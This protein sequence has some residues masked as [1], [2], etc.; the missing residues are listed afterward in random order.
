MRVSAEVLDKIRIEEQKHPH[1]EFGGFLVVKSN[2]YVKDIVF[3]MASQSAGNV[4]LGGKEVIKLN[5]RHRKMVKGWF[6]K[7]PITGLSPTDKNTIIKLTKFWGICYTMVLQSNGKIL[8]LKTVKGKEFGNTPVYLNYNN[9]DFAEIDWSELKIDWNIF[10]FWK[11]SPAQSKDED[12]HETKEKDNLNTKNEKKSQKEDIEVEKTPA[13]ETKEDLIQL[14]PIDK[15][16]I[17]EVFRKEIPFG[18][19]EPKKSFTDR[20][21]KFKLYDK[22]S[23]TMGNPFTLEMI[24][25]ENFIPFTGIT[26]TNDDIVNRL[27]RNKLIILQYTGFT[28]INNRELYENDKVNFTTSFHIQKTG[29]IEFHNGAWEVGVDEYNNTNWF[30]V[31]KETRTLRFVS[32]LETES[33]EVGRI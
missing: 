8:L 6:H 12:E 14:K 3:D 9:G 4:N 23:K 13:S 7:H 32:N 1:R 2:G 18:I 27:F 22:V 19:F 11:K 21:K 30:D 31:Y 17:V 33:E 10:K 25:R 16:L 28:D 26:L 5:P 29:V 24:L 20:D 15:E